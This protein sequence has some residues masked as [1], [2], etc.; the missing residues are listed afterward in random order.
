M[1]LSLMGYV[2]NFN[3]VNVHVGCISDISDILTVSIFKAKR[4]PSGP[5]RYS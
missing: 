4:I 2:N 5:Y 1:N 3:N